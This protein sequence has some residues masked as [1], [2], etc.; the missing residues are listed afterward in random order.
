MLYVTLAHISLAKENIMAKPNVNE[1]EMCDPLTGS[2]K[3]WE[4]YSLSQ[5]GMFSN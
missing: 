1:V 4:H 2:I 5:H 3:D